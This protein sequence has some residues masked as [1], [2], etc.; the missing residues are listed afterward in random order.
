M[1]SREYH[2]YRAKFIKPAQLP[3]FAVN[4]SPMELFLDSI[5]DKPN[6]TQSRGSEWHLG[7][8][9]MFG[10]HSGSFAVGR[11]TKTTFEKFDKETGDFVDQLDDSA[12]YTVVI[13][14]AKI[15]LLGIAK[16]S[17]LAPNALI[18]ARRIKDLLLATKAAIETEIDVR[19]AVFF[20]I[21]VA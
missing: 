17:K 4:K 8:I 3:L 15:G 7:N 11:T 6:Y 14:D 10:E 2:L 9:K 21:V 13:F 16:K 19:V 1:G 12:P 5:N 20:K 18:I